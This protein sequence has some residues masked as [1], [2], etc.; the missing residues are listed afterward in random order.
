MAAISSAQSTPPAPATQKPV[1]FNNTLPSDTNLG[2]PARV[3][4]LLM[5]PELV[6]KIFGKSVAEQ[7]GVIQVT[8]L[9][10]TKDTSLIIGDISIDYHRWLLGNCP[11]Q[12]SSSSTSA[13]TKPPPTPAPTPAPAPEGK[14]AVDSPNTPVGALIQTRPCQVSSQE[15][16]AV[17]ELAMAGQRGSWRNRIDRYLKAIVTAGGALGVANLGPYLPQA[18]SAFTS[19]A[20]PAFEF[21]FPDDTIQQ[22]NLINDLAYS[23]NA[24]VPQE[25]GKVVMAFFPIRRFLGTYFWNYY[26][27]EPALFFSPIQYY[28]DPR[29]EY[30]QFF[31]NIETRA[32][33]YYNQKAR[34]DLVLA[35]NDSR[36]VPPLLRVSTQQLIKQANGSNDTDGINSSRKRK[37]ADNSEEVNRARRKLA[38]LAQAA[39][40]LQGFSNFADLPVVLQMY[41]A[42]KVGALVLAEANDETKASSAVLTLAQQLRELQSLRTDP[43]LQETLSNIGKDPTTQLSLTSLPAALRELAVALGLQNMT[44]EQ[45]RPIILQLQSALA[46]LSPNATTNS[47]SP[48]PLDISDPNFTMNSIHVIVDGKFVAPVNNIAA[49]ID[50][51][52]FDNT[53]DT[54]MSIFGAPG[55][56]TGVIMGRYLATGKPVVTAADGKDYGLTIAVTD[57]STAEQLKFK[58][59]WTQA[60]PS[61]TKLNFTVTKTSSTPSS[62]SGAATN[63]TTT[64]N[65]Y[66]KAIIYQATV[67]IAAR[68]G[69][70]STGQK[71]FLTING[72][73]ILD[74]K[75]L[76]DPALTV[77][78][79]TD[80]KKSPTDVHPAAVKA[81]GKGVLT[82][83]LDNKLSNSTYS[84]VVHAV[85]GDT[86]KAVFTI[87]EVTVTAGLDSTGAK[88]VLTIT[89]DVLSQNE[90]KNPALT[91]TD[92]KNTTFTPVTA[93]PGDLKIDGK[94]TLKTTLPSKLKDS[95]YS[96]ILHTTTGDTSP[97]SFT[98]PEPPATPKI[99]VTASLDSSGKNTVLTITGGVDFGK[100][101]NPAIDITDSA[102]TKTSVNKA[103]VAE[104]NGTITATLGKKLPSGSA[105]VVIHA[106]TDLS[107]SFTVN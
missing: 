104:E 31:K 61:G 98:I 71:T 35:L 103:D 87:P 77:A 73:G 12:D 88:T 56:I 93:A 42:D 86:A 66:T 25:S 2:E 62:G 51:V 11:P 72:S 36:L 29:P 24:V 89:C 18:V 83:T 13:T 65:T 85:K 74:T 46:S 63:S 69:V 106:D 37:R 1:N 20:I 4:A 54:D 5:P 58:L 3:H 107:A 41:I 17:R 22:I 47:A 102:Q 34:G 45:L 40:A 105:S 99:T 81:D 50:S 26:M 28:F 68:A 10:L 60:I 82:A 43:R 67:K 44:G 7:Y 97:A 38:V 32:M 30:Q 64:S 84:V 39:Q 92:P 8:I 9:N 27:K 91:I 76:K 94:G 49:Q 59:T 16:R 70:D 19:G 101:K 90:L 100:L 6:R 23:V 14:P 48:S 96:L 75:D 33:D 15:V 21:A 79:S 55:S 52:T 57:G 95:T 78:D 80:S 53:S